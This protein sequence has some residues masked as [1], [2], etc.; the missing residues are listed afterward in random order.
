MYKIDKPI[1]VQRIRT[2]YG[3]KQQNMPKPAHF[4]KGA[5]GMIRKILQ[6]LES[7]GL[8]EKIVLKDRKGRV[9]TP[10]GK[11]FVDKHAAA[12]LKE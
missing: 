4:R 11:S 12:L 7:A 3:G 9:L 5:G 1:G 6:Q 2:K 10:K 8:I